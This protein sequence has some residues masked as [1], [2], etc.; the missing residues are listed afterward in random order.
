M[1]QNVTLTKALVASSANCICLSQ[2]GTG[3]VSLAINGANAVAGQA[4]MF[5][6]PPTSAVLD[7]QRRVLISSGGDDRGITFTVYGYSDSA[8]PINSTVTGT[9][10]A[11]VATPI[12]F[13]SVYRVV[14]SGNTASTVTVGTNAI[15][16]TPW[17]L[18]NRHV[19]PTMIGLAMEFPSGSATASAEYTLD[20]ITAPIPSP[21]AGGA[22]AAAYAPN[23]PNPNI[24]TVTGL[25]AVSA[26]ADA[27]V[28][29]TITAWRL[30]VT[31]GTGT[32]QLSGQQAGIAQG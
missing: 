20:P 9:N 8:A 26:Y 3:G 4:G 14:P 12:D 24:N 29:D 11:T 16:S 15:G 19:T 25:S 17:V 10:G 28:Q 32:A 7:T 5:S 1:G 31:S 22:P 27:V 13:A 2:T 30:T 21:I 6:T 18:A 23:S